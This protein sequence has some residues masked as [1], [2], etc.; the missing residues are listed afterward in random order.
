[1]AVERLERYKMAFAAAAECQHAFMLVV[2][3]VG[4]ANRLQRLWSTRSIHFSSANSRRAG[5]ILLK[6]AKQKFAL[7]QC[8]QVVK[9][10]RY[11]IFFVVKMCLLQ[12]PCIHCTFMA[13]L[14][15]GM[16]RVHGTLPINAGQLRHKFKTAFLAV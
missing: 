13:L 2:Q 8:G 3:H 11:Q 9:E 4:Q 16:R 5:K 15:L 6:I 7:V 14:S 12:I 10:H 1:M